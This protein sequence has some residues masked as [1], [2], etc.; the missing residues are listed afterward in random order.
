MA[1]I[2]FRLM[3]AVIIATLALANGVWAQSPDSTAREQELIE[4]IR[5]LN[6]R[7]DKLEERLDA[8]ED[9][10]PAT[11]AP[12]AA[13]M[14]DRVQQLETSVQEIKQ[15]T[16]PA[17]GSNAYAQL[18][19]WFGD[20]H[21]MR[22]Y[23]KD[24]LRLDS[25]DGSFKLKIGG[26]I[27][28]DWGYFT[29]DSRLERSLGE[30][31]DDGTEFRRARLYLSGAIHDNVEFKAQYDFAGGDADFKDV[32]MGL[33][34]V[35]VVGGI[36]VGHF[37]EPF[38][39][40]ELT[41]SKY[42]TFMERSLVNTFAPSRNTGIMLHNHVLNDRVTWAAGFFRETDGFGDGSGGRDYNG[43]VRVTGL[44]YYE[45]DGRKLVHL[46]VGYTHKNFAGDTLRY[47]SRP[48]AH[49]AS[50]FVDTGAF[51]AEFA[52][53]VS[54]EAAWVHGPFSLQGEFVESFVES[55]TMRDPSFWAASAQASYFLTGEHRPYKKSNGT[56]GNVKPKENFGYD[57]GQGAW[58]VAA[59]YSYLDL[60][61]ARIRGGLL[62]DLTVGLNWYLNPNLR[63]MWNYI[64]A[65]AGSR[66]ESNIFLWRFQI[67]F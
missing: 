37:K 4:L 5:K 6:D 35:P 40:E 10:K 42:T 17:V 39:I 38:S 18:P 9:A 7:I 13:V 11:F 51:E 48:E 19:Q 3:P 15:S 21:T 56:F 63:V 58:E 43:T 23:W 65:D 41:S 64:Y 55:R 62:R 29:E 34:N 8:R 27:Q 14:E 53:I 33:K 52:D 25:Q 44:P 16:P 50:R 22:A 66:G 32:Y 36:R 24:G 47:R 67:A 20:P 31:L 54:A 49:L 12:G 60:S 61:D 30:D 45:E 46:G 26:R 59:R 28:N 1:Q 57:G 2:S